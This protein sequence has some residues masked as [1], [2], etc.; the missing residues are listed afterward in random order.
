MN[1]REPFIYFVL[2]VTGSKIPR[3]LKQIRK[4]EYLSQDK[5]TELTN[6]KLE[7]LLFHSYNNVPYYHKILEESDVVVGG[8]VRLENFSRIPIL[9]K[10][11]IREEGENLYS[12]D[13]KQRRPYENTSGGSTGEPVRF[14]Q[15]KEY[16]EWNIATKLYFNAVL[17][18]EMGEP[19]I[20]FWGSDRDI[21]KGNLTVKDRIINFLYNRKFFNSYQLNEQKINELIN[22]NNRF[23]PMGYWSYMESAL[24]LSDFLSRHKT[25]FHPPKIVISTI[26]PLSDEIRGKIESEMKCKVYNQ[27]GS[28]EVGAI[29]CQ[30]REQKGLHTFPWWNY[31][32]ILD[33]KN[34]PVE[35]EQEGNVVVTTLHNYSM[36]LI[37]YEIGDVAVAGGYNCNCGK[38]TFLLKKV[39]G[40]TLGYFKKSDGSLAHSHFIVQSLFFRDWIKRFQ[41]IQ[42]RIDHIV[43]KVELNVGVD[44]IQEDIEDITAKIKIL[45]GQNC[46]VDFDF[47]QSLERTP[48]GKYLYTI[49]KVQS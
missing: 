12:K 28:R 43:I 29:A 42:D 41:V 15:D 23:K 27:Y 6:R 32:E 36:P 10:E 47:A 25:D 9:T 11:I 37:R 17:G 4:Y 21:I 30:C 5:I 20:K 14:I 46:W 38:N 31:V 7:E 8:Q 1:W 26:G 44:P 40:R 19:E 16:D 49:C 13:Y 24:E 45:M 35:N 2:Y 3:Y 34:R 33:E 22:L 48:S 18:K 39:L